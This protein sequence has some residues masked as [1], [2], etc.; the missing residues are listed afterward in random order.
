MVEA[1]L[2]ASEV[3]PP[4]LN[5][6]SVPVSLKSGVGERGSQYM[7]VLSAHAVTM[8]LPRD[9]VG[10]VPRAYNLVLSAHRLA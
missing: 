5:R 8:R 3:M 4:R 10:L 7:K 2:T 6:A 9:A 1:G